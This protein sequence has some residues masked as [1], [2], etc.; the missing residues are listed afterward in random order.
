MGLYRDRPVADAAVIPTGGEGA[1]APD[2]RPVFGAR[3]AP[4]IPLPPLGTPPSAHDP[5]ALSQMA[6]ERAILGQL[7][8]MP[9]PPPQPDR[10]LRHELG[11]AEGRAVPAGFPRSA[12]RA[13]P[14]LDPAELVQL[15]SAR[16]VA[17][18]VGATRSAPAARQT[19]DERRS[20]AFRRGAGLPGGVSH[21]ERALKPQFNVAPRGPTLEGQQ[22]GGES[23]LKW[24]Y[25][26]PFT[27]DRLFED[28]G[29]LMAE[30]MGAPEGNR[31]ADGSVTSSYA[32]HKDP[33]TGKRNVGSYSL[34]G[35]RAKGL[36]PAQADQRQFEHLTKQR[37]A[38]EAAARKAG[39]DPNNPLL[40]A[41]FFDV[42]NQSE[43]SG[44]QFLE[45]L[46]YLRETGVTEESLNELRFRTFVDVNSDRRWP[47]RGGL[48]GSGLANIE[49]K[50]LGRTPTEEE[51]RKKI[52]ADQARRTT[53]IIGALEGRNFVP[54]QPSSGR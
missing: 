32:G 37:E 8:V 12:P 46:P 33:A 27:V 35:D 24:P 44:R 39:L 38:Y 49:A 45:Q 9:E 17:T 29:T 42:F 54:K 40:A 26:Q 19:A 36:T 52:R 6:A 10:S 30:L 31:R 15:L 16:R 11:L 43:T 48:A 1:P 47:I 28:G 2:A 23:S 25:A 13:T 41:T 53:G 3:V 4:G 5:G 20:A 50:R 51:I 21:V 18:S 34:H 7:G 22:S 14:G